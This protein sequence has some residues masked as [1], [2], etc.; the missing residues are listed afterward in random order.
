MDKIKAK[1]AREVINKVLEAGK[2]LFMEAG[3]HPVIG[4]GSFD[5]TSIKFKLIVSDVG[6][7]GTIKTPEHNAYITM[8]ESYGMQ[9]EWIDKGFTL[10]NG[11]SYILRGLN[12]RAVKMPIIVEKVKDGGRYKMREP[13]IIEAF[14]SKEKDGAAE[15]EK[16]EPPKGLD[17]NSII[18]KA[19][20]SA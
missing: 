20:K 8:A 18:D 10:K 17:L 16:A 9:P 15:K 19:I 4:N 3:I 6:K 7:D 14:L 2:D 5:D 12:P 1:K 11:V 13:Q